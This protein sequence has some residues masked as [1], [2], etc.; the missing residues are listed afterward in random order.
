MI[1]SFTIIIIPYFQGG[2]LL[3]VLWEINITDYPITKVSHTEKAAFP[4]KQEIVN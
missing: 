3:V 2:F 4:E 1:Y